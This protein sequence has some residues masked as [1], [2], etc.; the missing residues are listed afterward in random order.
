MNIYLILLGS[1]IL[2]VLLDRIGHGIL[3]AKR[4]KITW[5]LTGGMKTI[6]AINESD[7]MLEK[8]HEHMMKTYNPPSWSFIVDDRSTNTVENIFTLS[9]LPFN[10]ETEY[11]IVTS[12]FHFNRAEKIVSKL[13]PGRQ[14]YWVFSTITP[15]DAEY[16]ENIHIHNVDSDISKISGKVFLNGQKK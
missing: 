11:Y 10:N 14:C 12:Q 1:N 8:L 3:F 6:D 9:K 7:V 5:F 15:D 4:D 16:W 2:S 13:M